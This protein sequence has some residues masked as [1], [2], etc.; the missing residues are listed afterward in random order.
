MAELTSRAIVDFDAPNKSTGIINGK[1]S[2]ILN[3]D[4]TAY[5]SNY[6]RYKRMLGNFWTPF[7]ID[8]GPDIDD[9]ETLT[10]DQQDT[11]LKIN[12]LLALLDSIQSDFVDQFKEFIT[13]SGT[14]ANLIILAQ[15]EVIHNHSYSYM[16]SSLVSRAKQE[17]VYEYWRKDPVM[18]K[19]NAIVL[20]GYQNVLS[21]KGQVDAMLEAIIY[22]ITLEGLNFYS[23][24]AFFYDLARSQKM[25]KSSTMINYINRDE[26]I[27]VEL[28]TFIYRQI[29]AEN[30]QYDTPEQNA[31]ITDILRR[32]AEAEI[33]WGNYIIGYKFDTIDMF[34]L[35]GYIKFMANKRAKQL[36]A[37]ALPFPEQKNNPIK[38]IKYFE[39]VDLGKTDFFEQKNR[40]Y[41]KTSQGFNDLK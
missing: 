9:F 17:E 25:L 3:W 11:F 31:L 19:R 16:L 12:G 2:N 20:D 41:T 27:H 6:G 39:D 13:D 4:D 28:F 14:N 33:E 22:D 30:P 40:Q 21:R 32:A 37:K 1:S 8:M 35:E 5:P 26:E 34:D 15:Q 18:M 38:W 24:F 23:G 7:E 29:L 36:G 10:E